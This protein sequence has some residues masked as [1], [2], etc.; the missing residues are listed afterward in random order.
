MEK[1]AL[2]AIVMELIEKYHRSESTLSD[3]F[4]GNI[5]KDTMELEEEVENLKKK[6]DELLK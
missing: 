4:S 1:E 5:Q 3:E 2:R 6:L